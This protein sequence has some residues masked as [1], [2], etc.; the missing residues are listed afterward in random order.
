MS[1]QRPLQRR[2]IRARGYDY[3]WE[4]AYFVTICTHRQNCILGEIVEGAVRLNAWGTIVQEEW[5][6]T[7][8]VRP[9]VTLDEFVVMPNHFHGI[10]NIENR[11]GLPTASPYTAMDSSPDRKFGSLPKSS[12]S[13]IIAQFKSIVTKRINQ[14]RELGFKIQV[15]HRNFYDRIIRDDEELCRAREYIL[16]NPAK[17]ESDEHHPRFVIR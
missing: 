10:L 5:R 3:S 8:V 17:S 16:Q 9:Y 2:S 13:S 12:L 11:R 4:G 7:V 15:W 1:T 14:G 6:K